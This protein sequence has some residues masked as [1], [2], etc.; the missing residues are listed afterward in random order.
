MGNKR[1]KERGDGRG[2]LE[3]VSFE[4]AQDFLEIR[5]LK[6]F[7]STQKNPSNI[8]TEPGYFMLRL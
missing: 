8:S 5:I 6:M 4:N 2:S 7:L 1:E 3:R